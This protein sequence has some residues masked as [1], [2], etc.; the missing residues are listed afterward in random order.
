MITFETKVWEQDWKYILT[1]DYLDKMIRNCNCQFAEKVL[2]INN[3]KELDEVVKYA[4]KKINEGVL[5]RFYIVEE[6]ASKALDYFGLNKDSFDGGY[7]YSISELVSIYLC[8]TDYL[9]HFSSDSFIKDSNK[10]WICDAIK[11]F[12]EREDIIVANPT[13]NYSYEEAKAESLFELENFYVSYGFSDQCYLI[14]SEVFKKNIYGEKN[15]ASERYPK[16]G[17]ELFEKRVDSFMRNNAF[18]RLTSKEVSYVHVNFPKKN[19]LY[20]FNFITKYFAKKRL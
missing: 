11:V 15:A 18:L 1:G 7:Y 17:G 12:E 8:S 10:N 4:N 6:Y 14:K 3:V 9:L 5:D 13:W 20:R 2:F 19:I 16:Y